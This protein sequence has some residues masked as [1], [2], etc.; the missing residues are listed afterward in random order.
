MDP[1]ERLLEAA[2][3]GDTSAISSH[4]FEH[5]ESINYRNSL[6]QS[7]VL[8]AQYHKKPEAVRM[9]LDRGAALTLHE[10]CAVGKLTRV[11]EILKDVPRLI[12]SHAPDGFTPLGLASY[13]GHADTARWLIDHG[14]N[15][16][17]A[18]NNAMQV[19]PLH[20]AA[21]GGHVEIVRMLAEAGADVNAR[22]QAGYV[23]LHAAALNGDVETA[24]VL[25]DHGADRGA[26]ADNQQSALDMALQKGNA[27][28]VALLES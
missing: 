8:L 14:A 26:R 2:R 19:A 28:M 15:V 21:S 17:L 4:L 1:G 11:Q 5:P 22:Q 16:N 3:H 23:P 6:G 20:A 10:A 12:D 7:A 9:L 25:L 18:A 13:F 24:R 27:G